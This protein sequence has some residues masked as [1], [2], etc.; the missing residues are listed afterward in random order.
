MLSIKQPLTQQERR[1]F[2]RL[3]ITSLVHIT[4]KGFEL[5]V[6]CKDVN[7]EGMSIYMFDDFLKLDDEIAIRFDDQDLHFPALNVD[8]DVIRVQPLEKGFL[9]ALEFVAIY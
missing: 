2:E 9:I 6:E 1:T 4:Y 3:N 7:T 5:K 8:A